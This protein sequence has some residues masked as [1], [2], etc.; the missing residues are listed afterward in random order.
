MR[1]NSFK[2][3]TTTAK[4]ILIRIRQNRGVYLILLPGIV[5]YILFAYFPLYGLTLAFKTFKANLGIFGSPWIGFKNYVF[6]FRDRAFLES[7]FRTLQINILRIIFTFPVPIFLAI[8]INEIRL[9]KM[10]KVLQTA[11]TFPHFLSWVIVASIMINVLGQNGFVNGLISL[12]SHSR[13]NFL[14]SVEHFLPLIYLTD[15]WKSAGWSAIIYLAAISGIDTEQYEAAQ[16]DGASRLQRIYHITLPGIKGTIIVMFI[17]A[18]GYLM[19]AGFDQLFNLSNPAT[20]KAAET[21][22]MYIY[23]ITFRSASDFS[24]SSAV[25]LFRSI[26]NFFMLIIADRLAKVAGGQGLF[27]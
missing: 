21:L 11:Y 18:M 7:V 12:V 15:I 22:D 16:I 23:R 26:I 4:T 24:F 25:S 14:G 1:W 2:P 10:K 6:V 5:W 17:L 9:G 3:E 19:S 13:V 20:S 27:G 8:A